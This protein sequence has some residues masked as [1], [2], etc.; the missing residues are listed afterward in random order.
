M[1]EHCNDKASRQHLPC[2]VRRC[3]EAQCPSM[4][5]IRVSLD[6]DCRRGHERAKSS[7]APHTPEGLMHPA[8]RGAQ[9]RQCRLPV[10][11]VSVENHAHRTPIIEYALLSRTTMGEVAQSKLTQHNDSLHR[12]SNA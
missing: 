6:Q 7:L 1:V 3:V 10:A 8:K 4:T 9:V 11:P 2:F 5:P 12:R